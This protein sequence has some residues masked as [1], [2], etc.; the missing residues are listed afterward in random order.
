MYFLVHF[1]IIITLSKKALSFIFSILKHFYLQYVQ[2]MDD[3]S[4]NFANFAFPQQNAQKTADLKENRKK[5]NKIQ[6]TV[7]NCKLNYI[8]QI[9]V[10]Q[11]KIN[12]KIQITV[13]Y[14]K[15]NYMN[16]ITVKQGRINDKIQITVKYCKLNYINQIT[17]K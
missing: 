12:D 8:N 15:L 2:N 10:Q 16:Q 13:K 7:K 1:L 9:T 6:I 4:V 14:C 11:C 3:K 5:Y 17:V